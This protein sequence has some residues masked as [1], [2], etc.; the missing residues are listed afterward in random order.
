MGAKIAIL[1]LMVSRKLKIV[2]F[3]HSFPCFNCG[4]SEYACDTLAK[5]L[6][7]KG[8]EVYAIGKAN[9]FKTIKFKKYNVNYIFIG[10]LYGF[11]PNKIN[12][13]QLYLQ[14]IR[15]ILCY[16]RFFQKELI[17]TI[18]TINPDIIHTNVANENHLI[19]NFF[20]NIPI[21]HTLHNDY[22]LQK[23]IMPQNIHSVIG[24][25][26]FILDKHRYL[27]QKSKQYVA[28][29]MFEVQ[30]FAKKERED[31]T[32]GYFGRLEKIK[33]I[34]LMLEQLYNKYKIIIGGFGSEYKKL[35]KKFP[36]VNFL[37]I[38]EKEDFFKK[39]DLLII[40]SNFPEPF[41]MIAIEA[42][43]YHI[44]VIAKNI[45]G[46]PEIIKHGKN[47]YLFDQ[48][49]ELPYFIELIKNRKKNNKQFDFNNY[50]FDHSNINIIEKI[51]YSCN[52]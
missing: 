36:N 16:F 44:P 22:L 46:L 21:I 35:K 3:N 1:I 29:N 5:L 40:P 25:S 33:G 39:I 10:E 19:W 31:F 6:A 48:Y 50:R 30:S 24:V 28:Y 18:K 11:T 51:Y 15:K 49:N 45:G 7:N 9:S 47:G 41:G 26:H 14:L 27:F 13:S 38:I 52:V 2:I 17:Y 37:G 4:G 42:L 20:K 23:N 43:A 34:E 12:Q 8:H 32:I